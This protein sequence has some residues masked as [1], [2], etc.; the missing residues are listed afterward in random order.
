MRHSHSKYSQQK[1][2]TQTATW[3]SMALVL[4]AVAAVMTPAILL[5]ASGGG[6]GAGFESGFDSVLHGIES[7]YDVRATKIPFMGLVSLIAGHATKGGVRGLHVAEI[8]NFKGHVDGAELNALVAERVGPG[9]KRMVRETSRSGEE[10]SLIFVKP[11]G[12]RIGMLVVD[13]DHRELDLVQMSL[14]PDK[15]SEEISNHH[16][17]VNRDG[18]D[19]NKDKSD[20]ED[21][22]AE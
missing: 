14:D 1:T 16:H 18:D 11:E 21:D 9:W 20:A 17:G 13:L 4:G 15:L 19:G 10:Q 2:V 12:S 5:A 7:R 22:G 3:W 8:E 6:M